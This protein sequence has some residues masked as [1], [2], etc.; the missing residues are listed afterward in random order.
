MQEFR[1]LVYF[2]TLTEENIILAPTKR[3]ALE[4]L[5]SHYLEAH[6]RATENVVRIELID[7]NDEVVA[8]YDGC[9]LRESD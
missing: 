4:V 5:D 9:A 8:R 2:D 3:A 7:N 1:S 6:L